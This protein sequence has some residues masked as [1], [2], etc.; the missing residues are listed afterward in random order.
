MTSKPPLTLERLWDKI[1]TTA[2]P[3]HDLIRQGRARRNR[4]RATAGL[5]GVAA[6]IVAITGVQA[7]G[8]LGANNEVPLADQTSP[9]A[10]TVLSGDYDP[11]EFA[12][13]ATA[14]PG[15]RVQMT[16]PN[17]GQRGMAFLM[18][19][20][21]E[22]RWTPEYYLTSD[23]IENVEPTWWSVSDADKNAW[24]D[25]GVTGTGPDVV[26]L[27]NTAKP[28]T[29]RVCTA[30]GLVKACGLLQVEAP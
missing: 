27:P 6:A 19:R 8:W 11:I 24:A 12:E 25:I 30:N 3:V 23:A 17:A 29:Y 1:P 13:A 28:G 16:F 20:W 10:P 14:S 18:E 2:A 5:A 21:V 22:G 9:P 7:T 26:L 4:R 15:T